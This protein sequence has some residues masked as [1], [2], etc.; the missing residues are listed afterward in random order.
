MS[1]SK[2]PIISYYTSWCAI[3]CSCFPKL[4]YDYDSDS[5]EGNIS[6]SSD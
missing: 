1:S 5:S 2:Y 3:L 6:E 4:E